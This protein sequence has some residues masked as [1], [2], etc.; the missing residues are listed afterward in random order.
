MNKKKPLA[1]LMV[2][3]AVQ[4]TAAFSV[5]GHRAAFATNNAIA[6]SSPMQ[7]QHRQRMSTGMLQMAS[8]T[9]QFD[10]KMEQKQ[11]D[12]ILEQTSL[13]S[14]TS[15]ESTA[16]TPAESQ[17]EEANLMQ[18]VKDAGTAG[19]L[20]Y[21]LWE[22]GFW[23]LSVP[24]CVVGYQQVT[25]HWPDLSNS[26]DQAKLGAEAFAFVNFARFAVPLRI[27]LALGTTPWIQTNVLDRFSSKDAEALEVSMQSDADADQGNKYL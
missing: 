13:E 6:R 25:G 2:A 9:E 4:S 18:Q 12:E 3:C 24:V 20:S 1:L 19:V 16:V 15:T 8:A 7:A 14:S 22:L 11:T 21:A 27:G 5:G 23:A 10:T 17:E 26:E